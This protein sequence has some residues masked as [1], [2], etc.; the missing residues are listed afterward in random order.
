MKDYQK[1]RVLTLLADPSAN[2][3]A[4]WFGV[5]VGLNIQTSFLTPP[6]GF[7]LF[8]LRGAAPKT[9]ST[10]QIYAGV[11]PFI[12]LQVVGMLA[13]WWFQPL[14]TALPGWLFG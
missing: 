8:Y 11:L 1:Q 4:V 10:G 13:V 6:F 9:V 3:T 7:S 2:V 12:V 14:A 5:M